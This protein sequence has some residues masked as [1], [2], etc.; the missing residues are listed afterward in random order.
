MGTDPSIRGN[1]AHKGFLIDC[2]FVEITVAPILFRI[3][4]NV[5]WISTRIRYARIFKSNNVIFEDN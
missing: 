3:V 5:H 1:I 2:L 4:I